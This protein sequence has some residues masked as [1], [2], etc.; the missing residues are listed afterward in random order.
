MI[1]AYSA[2][3][4]SGFGAAAAMPLLALVI[5]LKVLIPAW[6]LIGLAAG[7]ALFGQDRKHIEWGHL[8]KLAP[9]C[10]VGIA[11]GLAIFK[12]LDSN[13]LALGLGVAVLLYGSYS[14]WATVGE[15]PK[16]TVPQTVAA[17]LAGVAGGIL[18]TVLGTMASIFFAIY[19]DVIRLARQNYRA[20][21]TGTLL[22]LGVV[23]G[24]G[25]WAVGEFTYEVLMVF[26]FA[27]PMVLIGIFIGN[28]FHHGMSELAF[29]RTVSGALIASGLALLVR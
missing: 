26:A 13:T 14:L 4:A 3:G 23:R 6:T 15:P 1:A 25:Y 29:K 9:G 18:G 8:L 7:I 21:M 20:T 28:R 19:F 17:P 10:L 24:A 5:D 27:L 11:I 12:W 2:R 16:W 22:A